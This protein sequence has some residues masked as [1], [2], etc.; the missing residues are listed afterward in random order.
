MSHARDS[1]Y[2]RTLDR[3]GLTAHFGGEAVTRK[4]AD[5]VELRPGQWLL[6]L[7]CGTGYTARTLA[8]QRQVEVVAVDVRPA[9]LRWTKRR[10]NGRRSGARVHLVQADA[11]T[12]PFRSGSFDAVLVESVLVMCDAPQVAGEV[13]RALKAGGGFGCDELTIRHAPPSAVLARVEDALGID[14]SQLR[15]EQQWRATLSQAGF[16]RVTSAVKA[17][18]WL[19]LALFGPLKSHGVKRFLSAMVTAYT[20]RGTGWRRDLPLALQSLRYLA[21]GVYTARKPNPSSDA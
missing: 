6:D 5:C 9:M 13:Y 8:D 17:I 3:I 21:F 19:E 2:L 18:D 10:M 16:V 20:D 12:L 1:R 4:I 15:D 7:G 14:G 11:H